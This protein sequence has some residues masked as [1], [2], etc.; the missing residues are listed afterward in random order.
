V[1]KRPFRFGVQL[2]ESPDRAGLME[3]ARRAEALGYSVISIG[4]HVS[5]RIS[6]IPAL[7][8]IAAATSTI[9]LA[10]VVLC[11]D[12]R[13][14]VLAA[15]DAAA[16]DF[17]SDGRFELGLGAGWSLSDY[18]QLG[19]AYDPIKV[20]IE[21][22]AEGAPL[23]KD[24]L[25]GKHVDHVGKYYEVRDV[26]CYPLPIQKPHPPIL[27][28]GSGSRILHLVGAIA[29]IGS[30]M[31]PSVTA[32]SG[33]GGFWSQIG[34]DDVKKRIQWIREGAGSR[35]DDMELQLSIRQGLAEITEH[36]LQRADELGQPFGLAGR[37]LLDS[38][39]AM[40]GTVDEIAADLV[41]RRASLG[42]SYWTVSD[43]NLEE[44]APIV[45]RLAGT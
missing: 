29:D 44:M 40:I 8:A 4:D 39:Y 12:F 36:R 7:T 18:T 25:D 38:P 35:F 23:V 1:P 5:N 42:I 45:A 13:N 33:P 11:L 28:G 30:I 9:R 10:T 16:L 32:L 2:R 41:H 14:P 27:I 17:L 26:S 19:V 15:K 22:L 31:G 21:R 6:P 34:D 37:S 3:T 24:L 20:R 43:K